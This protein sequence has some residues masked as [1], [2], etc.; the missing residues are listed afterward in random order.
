M[1]DFRD[2]LRADKSDVV[3][4]QW[5]DDKLKHRDF[6]IR[7]TSYPLTRR[8]R[9]QMISF[10]VEGR[11]FRI[12]AAY[13]SLV[14]EYRAVL[15]EEVNGDSRL[16]AQWEYHQSHPG[17]HIHSCCSELDELAVGVMRPPGIKRL[18]LAKNSH[19]RA[20]FINPGFAIDD[21]VATAIACQRYRIPHTLDL[22][23]DKALP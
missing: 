18:P 16:I 12:L 5:S 20:L 3:I 21:S 22:L 19:R 17:W 4:G 8:W 23:S 6:P 7:R 11:R 10:R 14:P 1:T 2:I 9:W 15:A 13:H